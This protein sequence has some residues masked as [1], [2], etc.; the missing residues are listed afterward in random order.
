MLHQLS[1]TKLNSSIQDLDLIHQSSKSKNNPGYL[2][3]RD[4]IKE[5]RNDLKRAP[6]YSRSNTAASEKARNKNSIEVLKGNK[7]RAKDTI[8]SDS[9]MGTLKIR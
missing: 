8:D 6:K 2:R 7:N 4:F 1:V 9:E 3:Y 5:L